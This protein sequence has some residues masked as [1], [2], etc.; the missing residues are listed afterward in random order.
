MRLCAAGGRARRSSSVRQMMASK[1]QRAAQKARPAWER[2]RGGEGKKG[3]EWDC[4]WVWGRE[5]LG[6]DLLGLRR[7]TSHVSSWAVSGAM[8]DVPGLDLGRGAAGMCYTCMTIHGSDLPT[9]PGA[10]HLA[11]REP[12]VQRV[13]HALHGAQQIL[14]GCQRLVGGG[15][16]GGLGGGRGGRRSR[17]LEGPR[18]REVAVKGKA[19]CGRTT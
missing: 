3:E 4:C 10:S 17:A 2:A 15:G 7:P 11:P 8:G 19:A 5:P 12:A 16:R 1:R 18:G 13:D 14:N 9:S 6:R